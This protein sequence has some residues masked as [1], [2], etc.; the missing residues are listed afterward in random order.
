MSIPTSVVAANATFS[1]RRTGAGTL[2][3]IFVHGVPGDE[4]TFAPHAA[5]LGEAA[6]YTQRAFVGG[7]DGAFSIATHVDDLVALLDALDVRVH[8]V[9]WSYGGDVA[10][11]AALARP[12]R[13][14]SLYLYE[15]SLR[16][17]SAEPSA[18]KAFGEDAS[19]VF[20][21]I[22]DALE[23]GDRIAA[24]RALIEASGG[25]GYWERLPAERRQRY[26]AQVESLPL[27]LN[28][29]PP[30]AVDYAALRVPCRVAW[31]ARTRA[32]F[33][34]PAR[35]L[36]SVLPGQHGPV[37]GA[38]HLWPEEAAEAFVAALPF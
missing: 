12:E 25:A 23:R 19:A 28:A 24:M 29:P 38:G 14:S 27:L 31:G 21:P 4:R 20:A 5:L 3:T 11:R 34:V 13:V 22:A 32:V 6:T 36:A 37:E 17:F 8:L 18:T 35:A 2:R 10:I 9:G 30:A 7:P 1:L 26:V 33:E 16:V 15:P